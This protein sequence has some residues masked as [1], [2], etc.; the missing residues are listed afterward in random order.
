MIAGCLTSSIT[1]ALNMLAN[2]VLVGV[3]VEARQ[4]VNI[5]FGHLP[6]TAFAVEG[7]RGSCA[8]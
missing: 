4:T 7:C 6:G 8:C 1:A 3:V 2:N 5:S